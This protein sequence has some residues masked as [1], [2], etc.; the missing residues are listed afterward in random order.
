MSLEEKIWI[1]KLGEIIRFTGSKRR[2]HV[3]M[4]VAIWNPDANIW[5]SSELGI[6]GAFPPPKKRRKKRKRAGDL[7]DVILGDAKLNRNQLFEMLCR[8]KILLYMRVADQEVAKRLERRKEWNIAKLPI[9]KTNL[10][11]FPG[12]KFSYSS[13]RPDKYEIIIIISE[14]GNV[15][16]DGLVRS[17]NMRLDP[18]DAVRI[19]YKKRKE[20]QRA[21]QWGYDNDFIPVMF[22]FTIF[23][24]WTW[25]PLDKLISVLRNSYNDMFDHKVG[26][27]LKNKIGFK[28][29]IFRM[30][31]TL[32]MKNPLE[33]QDEQEPAGSDKH[34]HDGHHGW[35]PHYHVILFVPKAN[36]G[37]LD[38]IESTLKAR[39]QKLVKKHYA[40]VFG[41]EIPESY[42]P[43]LYEHESDRRR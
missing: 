10:D 1:N 36:L 28:Y 7:S 23:H 16:F 4:D 6:I 27:Q 38:D 14:G 5:K 19:A 2:S 35:H 30:E 26:E 40:K 33:S 34:K 24:D 20:I 3:G 41:K 29:R 18:V 31:E 11:S 39:W 15:R 32:D 9:V 25:Q 37:V 13:R 42:L 12:V 8:S 21:I 43:A 17:G 22:T